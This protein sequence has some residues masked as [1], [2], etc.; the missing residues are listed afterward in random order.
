MAFKGQKLLYSQTR[1][2]MFD[3]EYPDGER[4]P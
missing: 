3:V 2:V 4:P 1:R